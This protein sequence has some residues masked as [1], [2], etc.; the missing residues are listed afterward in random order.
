[1]VGPGLCVTGGEE[2]RCRCPKR[3]LP[4]ECPEECPFQPI[5]ENIGKLKKWI[6]ER[7]R[8]STFNTCNDQQL[9]LVISSPPLSLFIDPGARPTVVHKAAPVPIHFKDQVKH[10]IVECSFK[11]KN[12]VNL[13]G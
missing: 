9:P 6:L 2:V 10:G 3:E 13:E 5:K 11:Q 12:L 4:P 1:M 7:Y 8:S